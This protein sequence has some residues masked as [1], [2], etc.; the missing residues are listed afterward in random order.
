MKL[1]I[2]NTKQFEFD[3]IVTGILLNNDK[4]D[5][6]RMKELVELAYPLKVVFHKAFD[7]ANNPMEDIDKLIEIGVS[8]I[9]TSGQKA[10]ALEGASLIADMQKNYG[11]KITIM[12]G[13]G[14]NASNVEKIYN[15]TNCT[16]YHMS[17][18]IGYREGLEKADY[19]L[20]KN[21]RDILDNLK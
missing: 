13:G 7:V 10:N 6:E 12:P 14:V 20:I 4:I 15:I 5:L 3:G 21:V 16:H 8:R 11:D 18:R 19:N 17:G 9:L 1:E 2:L